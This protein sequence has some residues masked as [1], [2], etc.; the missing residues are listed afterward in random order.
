LKK[1]C[2]KKGTNGRKKGKKNVITPRNRRFID[3]FINSGNATH[4]YIDAGYSPN[5][6]D[7][8]ACKLLRVPK[9]AAEIERRR[10]EIANDNNVT[11]SRIINELAKIAFLKSSDVFNYETIEYKKDGELK[12][13]SIP[14]IKPHEE[15]SDA[16]LSSVS[17][18][19]EG[20]YGLEIKLYDKQKALDSLG[21]YVGLS[22]EAEISKAKNIKQDEKAQDIDDPLKG[23]TEEEIDA[24]IEKLS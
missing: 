13:K 12:K 18:I 14:I 9:I 7:V 5:G 16:A 1:S 23:M 4:A 17:S 21:R 6:A 19:K 24:E 11:A 8:S 3:N 15:L 2:K 10:L 22:N 20:M